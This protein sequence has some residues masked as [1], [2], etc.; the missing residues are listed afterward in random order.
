V[1]G[2][3]VV[4][5]IENAEEPP[6]IDVAREISADDCSIGDRLSISERPIV[7]AGSLGIRQHWGSNLSELRIPVFSTA[8]AK[9]IVDEH[10]SHAA[11]VFT[12][13]GG[14]LSPEAQLLP[15]ADLVIG[16]GVT[17]REVLATKPF[18]CP[19]ISVEAVET[20]GIEGFAFTDRV[21][22]DKA[23][24]VFNVLG[25]K[26]WGDDLV[27]E[28]IARL[29]DNLLEGFLPGRVFEVVETYFAR[30]VRAVFDVGYFCTVGEHMWRASRPDWALLS[31]QGRYMGTSVPMA[32]G[33]SLYD[34][35]VP[36]IAF[37]GD[38]GIGMY[39]AELKLA[40]KHRLPLLVVLMTDNAFG[41]I[42]SRAITNG[43]S[44][45][46][47]IMDGRSWTRNN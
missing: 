7:I 43:L 3:V 9:G 4:D 28:S 31:G 38:G 19:A 20:P 37:V 29:R 39:L 47:L 32:I 16:L 17:A 24:T 12:G 35:S 14:E 33:A 1:P 2:P 23:N 45:T 21:G 36:T 34:P 10:S 6:A 46:P 11:G 25:E 42:R 22:I 41:S 13:A 8:A 27:G 30:R 40:V 18:A 26:A 44:Q 15:E 5:L